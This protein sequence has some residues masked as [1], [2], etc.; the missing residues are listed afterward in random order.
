[1]PMCLFYQPDILSA[2]W[3]MHTQSYH[4]YWSAGAHVIVKGIP[5]LEFRVLSMLQNILLALE[6]RVVKADKGP[7]L[8]TDR[9]DP[10]HEAT[11]LEI[12]TVAPE[13]QLP[14]SETF[15]LVEHNLFTNKQVNSCKNTYSFVKQ[16]LEITKPIIV[17]DLK[18]FKLFGIDL[19]L[20]YS[21]FQ[22][23]ETFSSP[24]FFKTHKV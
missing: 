13:L 12:I 6:V 16:L 5:A 7:A 14:P 2:P 18:C 9:V 22:S 3:G 10:V 15:S 8:H 4:S 21:L 23:T 19:L 1:M 11:I 17:C 20:Q 24:N